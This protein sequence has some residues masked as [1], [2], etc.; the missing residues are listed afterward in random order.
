MPSPDETRAAALQ[1]VERWR[2]RMGDP[3][4]DRRT[5]E[6]AEIICRAYEGIYSR[7]G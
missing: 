2:A 5:V 3:F 1:G 6:A 4:S 7:A